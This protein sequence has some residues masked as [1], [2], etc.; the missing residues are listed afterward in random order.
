MK[1]VLTEEEMKEAI[2][3]YLQKKT[4]FEFDI[5]DIVIMFNTSTKEIIA[6]CK[7]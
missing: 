2:V 6:E 7:V 4:Q 1:I 5:P 3:A